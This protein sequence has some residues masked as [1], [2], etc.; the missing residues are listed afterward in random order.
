MLMLDKNTADPDAKHCGEL[1]HMT[2]EAKYIQYRMTPT[3]PANSVHMHREVGKEPV[4]INLLNF[5]N[6]LFK[7]GDFTPG[8]LF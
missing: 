7:N 6:P 2:G 3:I 5:D 1:R 8:R 4:F